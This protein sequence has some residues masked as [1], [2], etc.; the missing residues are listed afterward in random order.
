[1]T[2]TEKRELLKKF[3]LNDET[4]RKIQQE[5]Y[6]EN[7]SDDYSF[8]N[9]DEAYHKGIQMGIWALSHLLSTLPD[10]REKAEKK[11]SEEDLREV[12]RNLVAYQNNPVG[13]VLGETFK[14]VQD[15]IIQSLSTT[16][17]SNPNQ[18]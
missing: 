6:S 2:P 3:P 13:K 12:M 5:Y 9:I 7:P 8:T 14:D 18:Q 15:R 10:E 17:Q 11:Y 4:I 16:K 1:M